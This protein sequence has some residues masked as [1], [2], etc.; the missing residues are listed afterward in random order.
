VCKGWQNLNS[1]LIKKGHGTLEKTFHI[2]HYGN[3]RLGILCGGSQYVFTLTIFFI[4]SKIPYLQIH[5][6]EGYK[7]KR[8]CGRNNDS[9]TNDKATCEASNKTND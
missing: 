9:Q 5:Q 2:V 7:G 6:Q 1:S 4:T 3:S 8:G